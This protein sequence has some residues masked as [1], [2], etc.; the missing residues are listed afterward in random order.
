MMIYQS[1]SD[2]YFFLP[3]PNW[4]LRIIV[5][6]F[7]INTLHYIRTSNIRNNVEV[8]GMYNMINV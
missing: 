6:Q 2:L 3:I 7:R 1:F 5:W 8:N 4:V